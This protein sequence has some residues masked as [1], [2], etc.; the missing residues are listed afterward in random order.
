MIHGY[1]MFYAEKE[2]NWKSEIN[3]MDYE[4]TSKVVP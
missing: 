3:G 4:V 2:W 1:K